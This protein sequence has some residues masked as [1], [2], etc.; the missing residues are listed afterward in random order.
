MAYDPYPQDKNYSTEEWY[1]F[2][3]PNKNLNRSFFVGLFIGIGGL[4]GVLFSIYFLLQTV[5]SFGWVFLNLCPRCEPL[6]PPQYPLFFI[7]GDYIAAGIVGLIFLG[8]LLVGVLWIAIAGGWIGG[9]RII[10]KWEDLWTQK[11]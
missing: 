5:G 7:S 9:L 11:N 2:F 4:S 6:S 8:M 1:G 10:K 3:N